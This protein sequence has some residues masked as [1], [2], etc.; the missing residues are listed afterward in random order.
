[1]VDRLHE[2][3]RLRVMLCCLLIP[4]FN[5]ASDSSRIDFKAGPICSNFDATSFNIRF[6]PAT[7]IHTVAAA[8]NS[9]GQRTEEGRLLR[10]IKR[11]E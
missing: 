5:P 10:S 4:E 3:C 9:G 6:M 2:G 1:M 7:P 8:V 11:T